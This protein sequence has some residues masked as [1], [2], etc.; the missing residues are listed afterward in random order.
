M[1]SLLIN[2]TKKGDDDYMAVIKDD[3]ISSG[4]TDCFTISDVSYIESSIQFNPGKYT[5]C[6][7]FADEMI[8]KINERSRDMMGLY[9]IYVV[10][11]KNKVFVGKETVISD[12]IARAIM[13]ATKRMEVDV[14]NENLTM[15]A[16]MIMQW[17]SKK[18]QEVKIVKE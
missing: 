16:K 17:E 12:D 2:K 7:D 3:T 10:D 4:T 1:M 18:P 5:I 6:N 11:K 15:E 8:K 14:E 9:E 13:I